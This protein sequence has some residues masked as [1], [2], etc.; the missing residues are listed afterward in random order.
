VVL[1][2]VAFA[3]AP[4]LVPLQLTIVVVDIWWMV[5][6]LDPV[7][8]EVAGNRGQG[9]DDEMPQLARHT[10]KR[11]CSNACAVPSLGPYAA[12]VVMTGRSMFR[13][14]LPLASGSEADERRASRR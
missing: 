3:M 8:Q 1:D 6:L 4:A 13:S 5:V 11:F 2:A 10:P 14:M 12:D 9:I 7:R